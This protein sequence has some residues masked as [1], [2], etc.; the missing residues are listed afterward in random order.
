MSDIIVTLL[1]EPLSP[2]TPSSSPGRSSK[3]MPLTAWIAVSRVLK[4][5]RRS[6]TCKTGASF[7]LR[8][9]GSAKATPPWFTERPPPECLIALSVGSQAGA[10]VYSERRRKSS[11]FLPI[12]GCDPALLFFILAEPIDGQRRLSLT[13]N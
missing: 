7:V 9:I 2:T 6:D 3:L 13:I 5:I 10:R 8:D 1:P 12:F 4:T 11:A